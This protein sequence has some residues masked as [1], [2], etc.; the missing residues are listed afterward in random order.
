[1]N[2]SLNGLPYIHQDPLCLI[3]QL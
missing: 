1:M 2:K 3:R